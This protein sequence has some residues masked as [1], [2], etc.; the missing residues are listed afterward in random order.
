MD[1]QWT[2]ILINIDSRHL[3]TAAAIA[4][5]IVNGIYIE[6]YRNLAEEAKEISGIDLIDEELLKKDPA[7]AI[8]HV[9]LSP[10]EN[11]AEAVAFLSERLNAH[12]IEH[13][14]DT[15]GCRNEDWENNWKKYFK[16]IKVGERLLI[17][18]VWE[19]EFDAQG[20]VVLDLEPGLAFGSGTHE[21]TRLCLEAIEPHINKNTRM[22]DVGCGSGILSVASLLLGAKEAVGV[23]IDA[24]AVK[25]AVENGERNGFSSPRYTVHRGNLADTVT[26]TFDVIAANIVADVVIIFASQ[27][28]EFLKPDG[29]FIASG[30]I[31][32]REKDVLDAFEKY[33]FDIAA[34]HEKNNWLCFECF[35]KQR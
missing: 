16:P 20:R 14:I 17:R 13:T 35:K 30:I 27:V 33:G 6:D 31:D 15:Q 19:D 28:G 8:I 32:S 2:E 5:L 4:Q 3:D 1:T 11:P 26:G 25:T 10:Q 29:V 18:P 7:K 23:D 34:R 24:L 22:L 12:G 21:T 9:Y